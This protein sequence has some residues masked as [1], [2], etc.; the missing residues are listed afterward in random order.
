MTPDGTI[1]RVELLNANEQLQRGKMGVFLVIN[2][3]ALSGTMTLP[4]GLLLEAWYGYFETWS[5]RARQRRAFLRGQYQ[6]RP[7]G[8]SHYQCTLGVV[9]T[10]TSRHT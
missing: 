5:H 10:H 6:C 3:G 8:W 2:E 4:T 7:D 9:L 1:Y